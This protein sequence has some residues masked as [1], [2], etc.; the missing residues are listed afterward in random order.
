MMI[1]DNMGVCEY[2][3]KPFEIKKRDQKYCTTT[4]TELAYRHRV[5]MYNRVIAKRWCTIHANS[6]AEAMAELNQ[7]LTQQNQSI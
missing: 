5:R 2:C 3:K 4:C 1:F 7:V 6:S